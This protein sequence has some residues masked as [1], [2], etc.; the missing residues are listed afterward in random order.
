[1]LKGASGKEWERR[2]RKWKGD[3]LKEKRNEFFQ[4]EKKIFSFIFS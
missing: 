3:R 1:M 4:D 2:V